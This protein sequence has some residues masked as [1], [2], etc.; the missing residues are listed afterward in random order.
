MP[1]KKP[2]AKTSRKS[3]TLRSSALPQKQL[4]DLGA[5]YNLA[6]LTSHASAVLSK[7]AA[8]NEDADAE[9]HFADYGFDTSW[10]A[11]MNA[12]VDQVGQAGSTTSALAA[13]A[14]PTAT[15]LHAAI[16]AAKTLRREGI[17]AVAA[18]PTRTAPMGTLA[19][20]ASVPGI[21]RALTKVATLVPTNA[22]MPSGSGKD[23]R[24]KAQAALKTLDGAEKAHRA[25]LA[26]L[27][28]AAARAHATK[29]VL[30]QELKSVGRVARTV[31]PAD[32]HLYSVTSHAHTHERS[33]KR[34]A[35][36]ANG[37]GTG[38]TTAAATTGAAAA[39]G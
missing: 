29:G 13:Q 21:R 15:A 20:G 32:A 18:D 28:P 16:A 26:K 24:V 23:F 5:R 39:K 22:V 6:S 37:A 2:A 4:I 27:S 31:S 35:K 25:A 7:V 3:T 19:T 12:L 30:Q 1:A 38:P 34:P 10:I 17:T 36:K 14:L 11:S 33:R 8:Q 9:A